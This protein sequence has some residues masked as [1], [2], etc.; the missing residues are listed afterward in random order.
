MRT[1]KFHYFNNY[2]INS[3]EKNSAWFSYPINFND[4]FEGLCIIKQNSESIQKLRN[5]YHH[6]LERRTE[7]L[8]STPAHHI[9][10]MLQLIMSSSLSENDIRICFEYLIS[11]FE[12]SAF[13]LKSAFQKQMGVYCL[14]KESDPELSPVNNNLMW[15]HYGDGLRGFSISFKD[16]QIFD[17]T[18][19]DTLGHLDV[20]YIE[21]PL[22][23]CP[24]DIIASSINFDKINIKHVPTALI[25][26]FIT[27]H[28]HW[29]YEN[30]RRFINTKGGDTMI[31]FKPG[32]IDRLYI[33]EKMPRENINKLLSAASIIG[34]NDIYV[35]SVS[36]NSFSIDITPF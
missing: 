10:E 33:G 7:I 11:Y 31:K 22:N 23:I 12:K 35:C 21:S 25:P 6:L 36:K 26:S 1:F 24:S 34:M 29:S 32:A 28:R 18:Y 15:G 30:E 9:F 17:S 13:D 14:I 2:S 16:D 8:E 20:E 4:P 19:G 3:L 5:L 27:K